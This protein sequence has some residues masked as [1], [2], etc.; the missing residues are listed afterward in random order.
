[1]PWQA[2]ADSN[3]PIIETVYS[4][5]I[6]VTELAD[7]IRETLELARTHS[8]TRFL[9]DCTQLISGHSILDLNDLTRVLQ[10]SGL[11]GPLK[12]AIILPLAAGMKENVKFWRD[13]CINSGIL[14]RVFTDRSHALEWLLT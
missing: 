4:G 10:S 13:T 7:A 8:R 11:P 6:T 1:M 2:K 5:D 12:E 14:V 3:Y 9:G